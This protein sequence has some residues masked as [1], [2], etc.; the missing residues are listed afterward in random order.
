LGSTWRRHKPDE[1]S[2]RRVRLTLDVCATLLRAEQ[3]LEVEAN[4]CGSRFRPVSVREPNGRGHDHSGNGEAAA[5]REKPL[6]GT[7]TLDV[8]VG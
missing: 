7:R 4:G 8:V 2:E 1:G 6:N 5:W 3:S